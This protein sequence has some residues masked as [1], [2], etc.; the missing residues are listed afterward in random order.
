MSYLEFLIFLAPRPECTSDPECPLHL[1]CIQ[2]RCQDPCSTFTCG[3]NAECQVRNHRAVCS[4]KRGY[5]GDPYRICVER[6]MTNCIVNFECQL[7]DDSLFTAGCKSDFECPDDKACISRECQNPCLYEECGV[8]AICEARNH[9][10]NC[11]CPENHIGDPYR[12]C[13]PYECLTD[14]DCPD[15][16]AC[17]NEKCVDP[18]ECAINADCSP[19]NHRG[20]CT[21]RTGYTGDPYGYACT[22]SE[23]VIFVHQNYF[24]HDYFLSV[25]PPPDPGCKGDVDCPSKLACFDGDCRNPCFEIKPCVPNAD[26]A[27]YDTLPRRTMTCTC[28]EGYIGKGDVKCDKI[29][30]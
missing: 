22:K 23:L 25:P 7:I 20:Y 17:R 14:P 16:L 27:V 11:I 12:N 15:P 19:R 24:Y 18:C 9:R 1:A 2:E 8:N 30:E 26:C 4:C 10:A 21:C 28:R 29:G 6:E 3:T 5:E 13:R